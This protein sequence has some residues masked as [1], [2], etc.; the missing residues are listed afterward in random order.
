M[1]IHSLK[2]I[3]GIYARSFEHP[4]P[5]TVNSTFDIVGMPVYVNREMLYLNV[6]VTA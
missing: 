2:D 5:L 1:H 4:L 6:L 3:Y